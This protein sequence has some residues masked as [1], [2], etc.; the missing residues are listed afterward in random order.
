MIYIFI[1]IYISF[2]VYIYTGKLVV[3]EAWD[4]GT[5]KH[6]NGSHGESSPF[7]EGRAAYVALSQPIPSESDQS[8]QTTK[9][10]RSESILGILGRLATCSGFPF[11]RQETSGGYIEVAVKS[12]S[13]LKSKSKT[14]TLHE[15]IFESAIKEEGKELVLNINLF[16][17]LIN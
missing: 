7:Y 9:L 16:F 13:D 15:D 14:S 10:D 3:L 11:V 2:S 8:K 12:D 17:F 1:Y 6:P 4:E 5:S